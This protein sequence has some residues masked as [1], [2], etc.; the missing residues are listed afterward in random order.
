MLTG[1][2]QRVINPEP[3]HNLTGYGDVY[4]N[5][6]VHDDLTV[7]ALYLHDS[8]S[9]A[10][11]LNYDLHGL[12]ADF[13]ARVRKAISE[14][15]GVPADHVILACTHTHSGPEAADYYVRLFKKETYRPEYNE[16]LLQ[17]SAD[18]AVDAKA[19][20]EEC[21][22]FYNSAQAAEN[23]NRRYSFPDRRFQYIP[24]NKQLRGL[25]DEY[26]DREL[27]I[28]AFRKKGTLNRY[29]AVIT[30]YGAHPLCVGNSSLLA[31]ADYQGALRRT[32]EETFA[33]CCCLAMTGAA[34][35][36][37]PLL[38]ESGFAMAR[39]MG[40]R[41]GELAIARC[42]DAI[43]PNYD[44]Q[45]RLEYRGITL[46]AKD[47]YSNNLLP[48]ARERGNLPILNPKN[49]KSHAVDIAL[50][51]IGPILLVGMP[52]E[53]VAEIAAMIRW[54]SPFLKTYIMMQ[55]TDN[56]GYIATPNHFL[57]G[58]YEPS[59]SLFA[60]R[61]G[62]KLVQEVVTSAYGLIEKQPLNYPVR[63]PE[64]IGW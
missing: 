4:P 37:H 14:K 45:L 3:G 40:T 21:T 55:S 11:L 54:S 27:G 33:G 44:T 25:S 34:G 29:K 9:F 19:N 61:A 2:A 38:P 31:T 22:L 53:I 8:R 24:Q 52:G 26:L 35:D 18:A 20:A 57:W 50:L 51:G 32:V 7:T 15:T 23:M 12:N 1:A 42:Y 5:E 10:F 36:Q 46:P 39:N 30:V 60:Q 64:I 47:A 41:L 16:K 17:W 63:G 13:N 49:V 48:E 6:G 62:E 43:E 58:G 56:M 28:I 59:M